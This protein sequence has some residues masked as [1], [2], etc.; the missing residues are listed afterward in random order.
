M[1]RIVI[2][3]MGFAGGAEY[4]LEG[5]DIRHL[6]EQLGFGVGAEPPEPSGGDLSGGNG[7]SCRLDIWCPPLDD[8]RT[9]L[10]RT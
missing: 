3:D 9:G 10:Q 7:Q 1:P 6:L 5:V 4:C 8:Q 2:Y